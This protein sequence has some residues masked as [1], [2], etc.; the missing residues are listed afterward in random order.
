[1]SLLLTVTGRDRPGVTAALFDVLASHGAQLSDVE[2]VVVHER[3]LLGVVVSGPGEGAA[4]RAALVARP[5]RRVLGAL[6]RRELHL[7]A[8]LAGA[9]ADRRA[10]RAPV[11]GPGDH[12]AQ[13]QAV[14]RDDLLDVTE[15]DVV[16]GEDVEQCRGDAGPVAARDRQEQAHTASWT[17]RP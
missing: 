3:L 17:G 16:V 14:V 11:A 2:Q 5:G 10:D 9:G 7:D 8:E 6:E 4:L 12:H 1:M 15:L 13:Q